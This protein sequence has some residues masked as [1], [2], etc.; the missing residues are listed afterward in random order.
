M[1]IEFYS[2]FFIPYVFR[3]LLKGILCLNPRLLIKIVFF[4]L[5]EF[6]YVLHEPAWNTYSFRKNNIFL[7]N[8]SN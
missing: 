1:Y 5:S 3:N 7:I 4:Y 8:N 2:V 6:H